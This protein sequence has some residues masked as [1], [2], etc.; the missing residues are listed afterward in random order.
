YE[1]NIIGEKGYSMMRMNRMDLGGVIKGEEIVGSSYFQRVFVNAPA[2]PWY[3]GIFHFENGGSLSYYNPHFLGKSIKKDI[4]LYDGNEL[5]E[6]TTIDV[7]RIGNDVPNF[8]ISG[9]EENKEI[10]FTVKPYSKSSWTFRKKM[11]GIVP[12]K[13][14]YNE[15]P[16]KI[17]D[18]HFRDKNKNIEITGNDLGQNV[19]NSEYTTGFLY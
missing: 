12:N 18:L 14:V 4:S 15:Y 7:K 16:S 6:F 19:G 2:V 8:I 9:K 3:W 10:K 11:L 17:A 13:L 1:K 5:H